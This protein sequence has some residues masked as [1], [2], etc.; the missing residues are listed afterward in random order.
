MIEK[1]VQQYCKK[2]NISNK[3][4]VQLLDNLHIISIF[5]KLVI[6]CII[7][8]HFVSSTSDWISTEVLTDNLGK[9]SVAEIDLSSVRNGTI[10]I[11]S[12]LVTFTIESLIDIVDLLLWWERQNIDLVISTLG[13]IVVTTFVL[14]LNINTSVIKLIGVSLFEPA[15]YVFSFLVLYKKFQYKKGIYHKIQGEHYNDIK[16]ISR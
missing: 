5:I 3:L 6:I 4:T 10:L 12:L 14:S 16:S 1:C 7:S 13:T 15:F 9:N 8:L 2:R 11:L